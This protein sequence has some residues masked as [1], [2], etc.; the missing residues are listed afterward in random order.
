M[1]EDLTGKVTADMILKEGVKLEE[2]GSNFNPS[3]PELGELFERV[4]ERQRFL[5]ELKKI[6]NK[7]LELYLKPLHPNYSR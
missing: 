4:H 6:S 2:L 3:S 7:D 5:Q 1:V